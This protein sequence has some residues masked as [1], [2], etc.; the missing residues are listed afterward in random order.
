MC[1]L[2]VSVAA[3]YCVGVIGGFWLSKGQMQGGYTEISNYKNNSLI[4]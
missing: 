2:K 1:V 4:D 3:W